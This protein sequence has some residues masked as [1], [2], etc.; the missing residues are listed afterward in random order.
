MTSQTKKVVLSLNVEDISSLKEGVNFKKSP[1]DNK[2]YIIYKSTEGLRACKN[3]CKHQGGLFIEDIEDL[4]GRWDTDMRDYAVLVKVFIKADR[5]LC[6]HRTVKCTKHNWKLN[7]STM[8]YVNPPDSFLQDE[9]G[10]FCQYLCCNFCFSNGKMQD[11]KWHLC[12]R[13]SV[14]SLWLY[15]VLCL[16]WEN[17]SSYVISSLAHI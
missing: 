17:D 9:L 4:D 5:L 2:C 1:G 12:T 15:D 13:I 3:Q 8:K 16:A 11:K 10:K 7:V 14:N 6:S